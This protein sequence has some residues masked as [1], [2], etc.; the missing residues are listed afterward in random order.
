MRQ[1][2][3]AYPE[4]NT[5]IRGLLA[6][7]NAPMGPQRSLMAA[8]ALLRALTLLVPRSCGQHDHAVLAQ[9]R[10]A[11]ATAIR[12]ALGAARWRVMSPC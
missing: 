5:G 2:A 6:Q 12:L 7:W 9:R 1:T 3:S 4:T 10:R 8:L 11:S